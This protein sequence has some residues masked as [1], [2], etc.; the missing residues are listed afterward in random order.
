MTTP[1][2]LMQ[3]IAKAAL[4]VGGKLEPDKKNLEQRY[5]YISADKIISICGKALMAQGV[6]VIPSITDKTFVF[7]ERPNKSPRLDANVTFLMTISDG[8]TEKE[9]QWHGCGS[10]YTT[11]DKA[12]Y[13]AITSGHKYFL[14]KL[15]MVGAGNED[16]EHEE[17]DETKPARV[18]RPIHTPAPALPPS[19][20]T[21][22]APVATMSL[23]MAM[24]ETASDGTKYGTFTTEQLKNRKVGLEKALKA[25]KQTPEQIEEYTRKLTAVKV[26]LAH[27]ASQDLPEGV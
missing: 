24:S 14:M 12:L 11:P 3:K 2:N 9:F 4:D 19:P 1:N 6:V 18:A 7:T 25:P 27:H 13:K 8:E 15:L 26:L 23:E 10:D 16:G 20:K 21:N 5:D 17:D 22:G